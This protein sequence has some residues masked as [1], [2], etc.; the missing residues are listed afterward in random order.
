ME[1]LLRDDVLEPAEG[2]LNGQQGQGESIL[3]VPSPVRPLFRLVLKLRLLPWLLL[4]REDE[5]EFFTIGLL[6]STPSAFS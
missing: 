2:L 5:S 1:L 6:P 3:S 4:C